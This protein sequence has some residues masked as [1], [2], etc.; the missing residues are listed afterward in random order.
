MPF[1]PVAAKTAPSGATASAQMYL[2]SGSKKRLRRAV[3]G[4]LVD[5]AVGRGRHIQ[6]ATRRRRQRM[7]LELVRIEERGDLA[8][9]RNPEDLSFVA[10][11]RPQRAVRAG[12]QRPQEGRRRLG[13]LRRARSEEHA[14]VAVNREVLDVALEE[15][16]LRR[17]R[18]ERR[19]GGNQGR[20]R[21]ADG[22]PHDRTLRAAD[23][24]VSM[25]QR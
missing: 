22:H 15:V 12:D 25:S 21:Q 11:A 17:D 5:A 3:R 19:R 7:N 6:A 9:A 14:S 1:S 13:D 8:V 10:G 24:L 18:P 23:N 20:R 2:S 4:D 16:G